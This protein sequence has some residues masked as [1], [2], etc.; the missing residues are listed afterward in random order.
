MYDP[1]IHDIYYRNYMQNKH[2]MIGS[3]WHVLSG[4]NY[5]P[6]DTVKYLKKEPKKQFVY[7]GHVVCMYVF[8]Y[9]DFF[10]ITIDGL[11]IIYYSSCFYLHDVWESVVRFILCDV[12]IT[13]PAFCFAMIH[14]LVH[15]SDYYMNQYLRFKVTNE[16]K[17]GFNFIYEAR[18]KKV[19]NKGLCEGSGWCNKNQ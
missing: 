1:E 8:Y 7:N 16:T 12:G 17:H 11:I 13:N 6:I 2:H 3:S 9:P 15:E 5:V 4:R 19:R 18:E 14:K 10:F